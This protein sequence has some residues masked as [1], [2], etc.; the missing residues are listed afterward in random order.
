MANE[1]QTAE[2]LQAKLAE[3]SPASEGL[4]YFLPDVCWM[5]EKTMAEALGTHTRAISKAKAELEEAGLI[6]IRREQNNYKRISKIH[7]ILKV[8]T[9]ILLLIPQ[10][11]QWVLK[12]RESVMSPQIQEISSIEFQESKN[13]P[14]SENQ[15]FIEPKIPKVSW[16]WELLKRYSAADINRMS[17]FEQAELYMEVGFLVL[18]THYP[19]FGR[20]GDVSCSCKSE[21]CS[22]IGKHPAVKSYRLLTPETY[23]KHRSRY[24]RR[25]KQDKDLNIGFKPFGYSVLDVDYRH[26]GEVSLELLREEAQGLDETLTAA[27]ANGLHLYTSTIGLSQSVELLGAGLDVRGDKT[28]GFIVA[29]CSTHASGKQ[30]RWESIADLQDIP[31]EWLYES[32]PID[33]SVL[34]RKRGKTGRSLKHI[35]I[36]IN[37]YEGYVIPE[38]QRNDTLFKLASRLRGRGASEEQIYKELIAL[39]DTFCE[40]SKNPNN[41]VTEGELC[42]IAKSAARYPT[43]AEKLA[44]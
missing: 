35:L 42:G 39:R 10:E 11:Y 22:K 16:N 44:A 21:V 4:Y 43:N 13:Q 38:H 3:L 17:R 14:I 2:D 19:K 1:I 29:P 32:D 40:E 24:L 18:P 30:Y 34:P 15:F 8:H 37:F 36:P 31:D 26:G 5:T 20:G 7:R 28:T 6:E 25:F 9:W 23:G 41:A 27:S 33:K 12:A